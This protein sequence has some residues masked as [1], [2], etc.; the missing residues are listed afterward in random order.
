[1]KRIDPS[2]GLMLLLTTASR[3]IQQFGIINKIYYV[4]I[5]TCFT[6]FTKRACMVCNN[7]ILSCRVLNHPHAVFQLG[8][9]LRA[10]RTSRTGLRPARFTRAMPE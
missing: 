6:N 7:N 1:M 5:D 4:N 10:L 2:P 8:L 9:F 3:Y